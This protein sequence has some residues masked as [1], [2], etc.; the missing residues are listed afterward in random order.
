MRF[1]TKNRIFVFLLL[2]GFLWNFYKIYQ[3]SKDNFYALTDITVQNQLIDVGE[4]KKNSIKY[5]HFILKN[6]GDS[7]IKLIEIKPDCSCTR[8][9]ID[10][11]RSNKDI[12]N[13]KVSFDNSYIG[14][15]DR[16]VSVFVNTKD[17][18]KILRLKGVVVK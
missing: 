18:P 10:S 14:A 17:S 9:N 8:A 12:L 5:A 15:F 4:T 7:P 1:L 3:N 16:T 2:I 6:T 13:I 11:S